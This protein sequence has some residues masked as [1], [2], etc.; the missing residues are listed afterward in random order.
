MDVHFPCSF[1]DKVYYITG[2]HGTLI[3]EA[4]VEDIRISKDRTRFG[5]YDRSYYFVLESDEVYFTKEEAERHLKKRA[6]KENLE[7]DN[8]GTN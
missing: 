6:S 1:G 8:G 7:V 4:I 3:G 5:V 2:V